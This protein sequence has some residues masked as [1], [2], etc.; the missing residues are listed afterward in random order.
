MQFTDIL[1]VIGGL[2]LFLYG[3]KMMSDGLALVAGSRLKE[4]LEKLTRNRY[5]GVLVGIVIAAIIQSSN[6]TTVMAVGFVNAGLMDLSQAVGVIIGAKVGTTMTGQLLTNPAA[7]A[8]MARAVNPYGD[9]RACRRIADA[10]A[11]HFGI[12]ERPEDFRA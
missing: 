6:A 2:S 9:G 7:Y 10:I 5:V 3:M 8:A 4:I 12:G 1:G 11:W